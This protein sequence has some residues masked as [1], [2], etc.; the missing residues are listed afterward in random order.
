MAQV[1]L[2]SNDNESLKIIPGEV[3]QSID[4]MRFI[5]EEISTK[6]HISL[7]AQYYPTA[8]VK[9]HLKLN[10]PISN[11]EYQQVIDAFH[12]LGFYHG[13][14]QDLESH[15]NLR[16]DFSKDKPFE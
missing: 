13:W 4:I 1:I 3:E 14:I 7:M 6:L 5:A 9:N 11:N 16:P 2:V 12:D 15:A 10:R 8:L